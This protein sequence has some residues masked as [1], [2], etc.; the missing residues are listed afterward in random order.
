VIEALRHAQATGDVDAELELLKR[1]LER[2]RARH[3][4]E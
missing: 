4:L 2:A 1:Q 3:K